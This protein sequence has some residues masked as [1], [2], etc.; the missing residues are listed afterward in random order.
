ML[1]TAG[2]VFGFGGELRG[3]QHERTDRLRFAGFGSRFITQSLLLF[4][5][6]LHGLFDGRALR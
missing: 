5:D 2:M 4:R 6:D 3:T 1:A